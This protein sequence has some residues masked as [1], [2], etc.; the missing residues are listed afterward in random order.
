[1]SEFEIP[2]E[3][4]GAVVVN[5]GPDFHV[6]IQMVPVPDIGKVDLDL[7]RVDFLCG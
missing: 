3:C 2:K 7:Y 6:E 4:K 5:E 1:M